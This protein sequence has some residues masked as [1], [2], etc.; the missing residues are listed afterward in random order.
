M[1]TSIEKFFAEFGKMIVTAVILIMASYKIGPTA[2]LISIIFIGTLVLILLS[3]FGWWAYKDY[4]ASKHFDAWLAEEKKKYP[5]RF[6]D[7]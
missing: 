5:E 6:E 4:K 7:F 3:V 2:G 1:I